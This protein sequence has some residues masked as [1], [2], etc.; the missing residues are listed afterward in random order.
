VTEFE[1]VAC[2]AA[3][4]AGRMLVGRFQR[5]PGLSVETKG[6]HDFVTEVDR[7]AEAIV[8]SEIRARYPDHAILAEEG[9]PEAPPGGYRWIVDPLD[10][11]TN[12][13]HGVPVFGVSVALEDP[14]GLLAGATYDPAREEMFHAARGRGA[15]LNGV[16]IACSRL[17]TLDEA[18][19]ATGFPFR[20][21]ERLDAYV[22]AFT[23][24]V[25]AAAGL[26][27]AGSA[28][29]DLAYTAC[30]RYD[31]FWEI[32]L[33]PW[34]IAAGVLLVREAGG[35]VTDVAGGI[36]CLSGD[37]VAAGPELHAQMLEITR[38]SLGRGIARPHSGV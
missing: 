33:C 1:A 19:I 17:A 30:G 21:L 11:T 2:A 34:D 10:G 22:E 4:E 36:E 28:V 14:S 9:S 16:P 38:R 8:V 26:R 3:R 5:E 7:Q 32:G 15:W 13:I 31:G 12:F 37:L 27:R 20:R 35:V 18:L 24:F 6:L 29:L 23:A 25:R